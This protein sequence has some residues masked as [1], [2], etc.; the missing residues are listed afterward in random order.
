MYPTMS[1]LLVAINVY[2]NLIERSFESRRAIGELPEKDYLHFKKQLEDN[3]LL[4]NS[5]DETFIVE[6]QIPSEQNEFFSKSL[7]DLLEAPSRLLN[8]PSKFYIA[9]ED[10][11]YEGD[12]EQAPEYI[13]DYLD[14]ALF[15]STLLSLADHPISS[16]SP[17]AIFLH[18]EK[19]ELYLAYK[20]EDIKRLM[21][22]QEFIN[23]FVSAEIH[24]DQKV[25]IIKSVLLEMLKNNE[26]DRITL[27]CLLKRFSEFIERVN[28]NYQLYVSE[29]S[30]EKIKAQVESEKFEFTLKLNRVF[31]EIQNQLLA[32]PVALV[33]VGSQMKVTNGFSMVNSTIWCGSIVFG[34]FMSLLIRNQ[35]STLK[36]IQLEMDSQWRAIEKKHRYVAERLGLYYRQLQNRYCLQKWFLMLVSLVVSGSILGST[37]LLFYRCQAQQRLDELFLYG[38]FG[39]MLYILICL[40]WSLRYKLQSVWPVVNSLK[41]LIKL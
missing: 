13:R 37:L 24:K 31:S 21:G 17:R 5:R 40:L 28:A 19:L 29:F 34:F 4:L 1:K 33:L 2:K 30:F 39:G 22:L 15:S 27:P 14:T 16:G 18:G 7:D 41:S 3:N 9:D 35:R 32:V 36:A 8:P 26:I 6:F 23:E 25:T 12:S 10:V 11:L 20:R 38:G